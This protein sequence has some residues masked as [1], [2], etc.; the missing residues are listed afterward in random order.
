MTND[1]DCSILR[2]HKFLFCLN[3]RLPLKV[4]SHPAR[5]FEFTVTAV[6]GAPTWRRCTNRASKGAARCRERVEGGDEDLWG[7]R[8]GWERQVGWYPGPS[9]SRVF[10][11]KGEIMERQWGR[12]TD[13][14][15][16]GHTESVVCKCVSIHA[17]TP[18]LR[19]IHKKV[20]CSLPR[21]PFESLALC[22]G[23]SLPP[24]LQ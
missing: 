20:S 15:T 19:F 7:R 16:R 1:L 11:R 5:S 10:W 12:P 21:E 13:S 22:L 6:A 17:C 23:L 9:G 2:C 8:Q 18:T 3:Q 24:S 4:F 14:G